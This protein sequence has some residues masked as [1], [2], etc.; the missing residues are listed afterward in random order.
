MVKL[1]SRNEEL[2][3]RIVKLEKENVELKG[4]VDSLKKELD[5]SE[6]EGAATKVKLDTT[7]NKMKFI[8]VDATPCPG[9]ANGRIQKRRTCQLGSRSE[10]PDMEKHGGCVG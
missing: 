8:N 1:K 6:A 10:D 2:G 4:Q 7:L 5:K 3:D 9:R